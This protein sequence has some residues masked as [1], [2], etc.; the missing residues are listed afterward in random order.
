MTGGVPVRKWI[1]LKLTDLETIELNGWG[2]VDREFGKGMYTLLYC[3]RSTNKDL[4]FT[5][6]GTLLCSMLCANWIAA[7][8]WGER[9]HVY[10]WLGVA[11]HLK[12]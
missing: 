2:R 4:L 6:H 5:A 3:I 8:V 10:V 9:I 1:F 7:G 11:V 12:L